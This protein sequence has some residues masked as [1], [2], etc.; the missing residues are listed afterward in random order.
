MIPFAQDEDFVERW[1]TLDQ[2]KQKFHAPDSQAALVS[3][4]GVG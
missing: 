3:L 4:G 1:A 2:V